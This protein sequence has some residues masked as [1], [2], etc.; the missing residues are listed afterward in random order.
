M[1]PPQVL[2]T[3]TKNTVVDK[4]KDHAR[5][6]S[7]CFL[8]QCRRCI[9]R[10]SQYVTHLSELCCLYS[11]RKRQIDQLDCDITAN[12]GKTHFES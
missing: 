5:P 4:I 2:T 6:R 10:L 1:S 8:L 9:E 7:I 3:M 12:R 11:C